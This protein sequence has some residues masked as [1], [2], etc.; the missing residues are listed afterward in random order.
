L[1]NILEYSDLAELTVV[2]YVWCE[3]DSPRH[4]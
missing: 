3:F 2:V 4:T 1:L